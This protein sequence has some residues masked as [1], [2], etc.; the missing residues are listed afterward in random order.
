[1]I[2][3]R[4]RKSRRSGIYCSDGRILLG[5]TSHVDPVDDQ[6]QKAGNMTQMTSMI[7]GA[8]FSLLTYW[9][10]QAADPMRKF[11]SFSGMG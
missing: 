8:I 5:L 6:I 2:Y 10:H 7:A 9:H 1:M 11:N 3:I 4:K